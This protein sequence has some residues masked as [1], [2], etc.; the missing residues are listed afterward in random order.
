MKIGVIGATGRVG[1]FITAE[2]LDRGHSVRGFARHMTLAHD[3][4]LQLIQADIMAM[5]PTDIAGL[6][7]LVSAYRAPRGQERL[8]VTAAEAL[9]NLL[10]GTGVRLLVVGGAGSSF[11]DETKT[12]RFYETPDFPE[13]I[14][15][16]SMYMARSTQV[17]DLAPQLTWTYISPAERFLA[18]GPK[19]GAY[20]TSAG[21]L[22]RDADGRSEISMADYAVAVVDELEHPQY[23]N[24]QMAVAW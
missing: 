16:T 15:A 19:T 12:T 23:L 7:A 10:K 4:R 9:A 24:S 13:S 6:D 14:Y 2:A 17:L 3:R 8:Y 20:R 21:I 11:A 5:T 18:D 22:L 1:K